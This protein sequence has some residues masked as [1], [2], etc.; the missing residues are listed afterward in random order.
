[1]LVYWV[2]THKKYYHGELTNRETSGV[3]DHIFFI[4]ISTLL[5]T[6]LPWEWQWMTFETNMRDIQPN[7]TTQCPESNNASSLTISLHILQ[8]GYVVSFHSPSYT[9]LHIVDHLERILKDRVTFA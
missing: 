2:L 3:K 4:E 5:Q 9:S 1:M 7:K 6:L 8:A